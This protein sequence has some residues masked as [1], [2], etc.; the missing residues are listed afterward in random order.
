MYVKDG[1]H[2]KD[3]LINIFVWLVKRD[4]ENYTVNNKTKREIFANISHRKKEN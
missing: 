2:M 4:M 3:R 1:D